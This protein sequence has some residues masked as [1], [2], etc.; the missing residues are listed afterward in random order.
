MS[1]GTVANLSVWAKAHVNI[2]K[3]KLNQQAI[4]GIQS[5]WHTVH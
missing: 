4:D 2:G 1:F 3:E 5:Y